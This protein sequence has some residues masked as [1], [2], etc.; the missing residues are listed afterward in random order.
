MGGPL[1]VSRGDK[2]VFLCCK[3]CLEKI[4]ADPAKYFGTAA[5][6]PAGD[7]KHDHQGHSH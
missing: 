3:G 6:Q 2:S 5:A 1:K 4:Q 7:A